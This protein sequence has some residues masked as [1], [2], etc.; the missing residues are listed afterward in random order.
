MRLSRPDDT[1]VILIMPTL[2]RLWAKHATNWLQWVHY[3]YDWEMNWAQWDNYNISWGLLWHHGKTIL[4]LFGSKAHKT[5]LKS[6][7]GCVTEWP[8]HVSHYHPAS[9]P[10]LCE[11]S[12]LQCSASV[13]LQANFA[14]FAFFWQQCTLCTLSIEWK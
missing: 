13:K 12:D 4:L 14:T 11:T 9:I 7:K 5:I 10:Y 6:C 3:Y 8:A 1:L 2:G